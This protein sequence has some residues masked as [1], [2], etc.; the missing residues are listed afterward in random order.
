MRE[1]HLY[2]WNFPA[3][4]PNTR[5]SAVWRYEVLQVFYEIL[6]S[7]QIICSVY[8]VQTIRVLKIS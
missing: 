3:T 6:M 7:K 5:I 4:Y 8:K 1:A 2:L